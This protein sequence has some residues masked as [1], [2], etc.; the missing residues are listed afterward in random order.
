MKHA[1]IFSFDLFL[2]NYDL[3]KYLIKNGSDVKAKNSIDQTAIMYA[4]H[5]GITVK[6]NLCCNRKNPISFNFLAYLG[7]L[8]IVNLLIENGAEINTKNVL[9]ETPLYL[10]AVAAKSGI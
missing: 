2:G 8:Q 7:S 9:H 6:F 1:R 10:A 4:A 5:N 3:A